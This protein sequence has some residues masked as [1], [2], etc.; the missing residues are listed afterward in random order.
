MQVRE[1]SDLETAFVVAHNGSTLR[2]EDA[3]KESATENEIEKA[4]ENDEEEKFIV[5]NGLRGKVVK[6]RVSV[7]YAPPEFD[8]AEANRGAREIFEKMFG[9]DPERL[10]HG[11]KSNQNPEIAKTRA[12]FRAAAAALGEDV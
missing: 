10:L 1:G 6:G 5:I 8:Q 11:S 9:G 3:S 4:A 7:Q 12:Q 2:Q